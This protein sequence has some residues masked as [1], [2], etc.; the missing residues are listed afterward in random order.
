M[1]KI[2]LKRDWRY[3]KEA[4]VFVQYRGETEYNVADAVADA[5]RKDKVLKKGKADGD[6]LAS[7]APTE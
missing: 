4:G 2:T 3:R 1:E 7:D 5:A 6:E